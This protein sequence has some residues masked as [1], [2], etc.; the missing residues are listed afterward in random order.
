M[1]QIPKFL[2]PGM[3]SRWGYAC[4]FVYILVDMF[5]REAVQCGHWNWR[6]KAQG[7]FFPRILLDERRMSS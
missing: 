7:N 5:A 4:L 2:R 6:W 1:F 3:N